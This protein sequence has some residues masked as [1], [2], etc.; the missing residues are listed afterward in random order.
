MGTLLRTS[1]LASDCLPDGSAARSAHLAGL[2]QTLLE[3]VLVG[4][5]VVGSRDAAGQ[6]RQGDGNKSLHREI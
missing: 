1:R 6:R 3:K 4:M 2:I 5:A